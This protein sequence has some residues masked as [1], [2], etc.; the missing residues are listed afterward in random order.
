[1]VSLYPNLPRPILR[2]PFDV[3]PRT[4]GERRAQSPPL[5]IIDHRAEVAKQNEKLAKFMET[6]LVKA[7]IEMGFEVDVI[8]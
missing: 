4:S 2:G 7:A 1:M 8:K 3:P 5:P 6:D